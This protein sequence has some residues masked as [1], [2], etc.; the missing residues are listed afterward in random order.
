MGF[1]HSQLFM[2][3]IKYF[4]LLSDLSIIFWS[5][6]LLEFLLICIM[7]NPTCLVILMVSF[8]IIILSPLI[9]YIANTHNHQLILI[10]YTSGSDVI[11]DMS[12]FSVNQ[13]LIDCPSNSIQLTHLLIR[14]SAS[15]SLIWKIIIDALAFFPLLVEYRYSH[16]ILYGPPDLLVEC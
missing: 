11:P 5:L 3:F 4:V 13:T 6:L 12:W 10:N 7:V 8:V 15:D 9:Q 1:G 14:A 16:Q 2:C